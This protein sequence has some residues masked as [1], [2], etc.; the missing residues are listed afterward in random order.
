MNENPIYNV[1][2][3]DRRICDCE[4]GAVNT[5]TYREWIK[6]TFKDIYGADITDRELNSMTDEAFTDLIDELEWLFWK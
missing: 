1:A 6:D 4:P 2:N 3:L 5:Q